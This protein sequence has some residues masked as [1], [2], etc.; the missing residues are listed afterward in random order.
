MWDPVLPLGKL[1]HFNGP[2]GGAKSPV[3]ID[4]MARV[5]L[6]A[7]MPNDGKNIWGGSRR[8]MLCN[9]EDDVSD[10]T[11]PRF[12]LAGGFRPLLHLIRGRS[13]RTTPPAKDCSLW[14]ATLALS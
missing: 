6:G 13:R 7:P 11:M 4:V 2:Q 3:V 9:I 8:V 12:D 10:T 1:A 14:I 5:T